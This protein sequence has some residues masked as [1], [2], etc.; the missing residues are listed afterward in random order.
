MTYQEANT[1]CAGL[2][3]RALTIHGKQSAETITEKFDIAKL[4]PK[5]GFWTLGFL[6]DFSRYFINGCNNANKSRPQIRAA[7]RIRAAFYLVNTD[8]NYVKSE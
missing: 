5:S 1:Y 6:D 2:G 4:V 8:Q 7:T 3:M